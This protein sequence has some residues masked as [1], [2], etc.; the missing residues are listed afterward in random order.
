MITVFVL[1]ANLDLGTKHCTHV[2]LSGIHF[3]GNAALLDY[4]YKMC[5][6]SEVNFH[7][8]T[9]Q[10]DIFHYTKAVLRTR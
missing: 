10:R 3:D 5:E 6:G 2:C 8:S 7:T 4:D 9:V 1:K